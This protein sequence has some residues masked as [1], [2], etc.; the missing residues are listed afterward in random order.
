MSLCVNP[1]CPQP[2]NPD[3]ALFC[4]SCGSELLLSGRYR[5]TQRL[6]KQGGFASTY[7][8]SHGGTLK[9]LKILKEESPKA[10][11]LFQREIEVLKQSQHP[12][13]P[14]GEEYF[15]TFPKGHSTPLHCLVMEKVEGMDL[16]EYISEWGI[17][18]IDESCALE[19]LFQLADILAEIHGQGLLHRDIKPSNIILRPDGQLVLIDFG[20]VGRFSS[21]QRGS[22]TYVYTPGYAAPEQ[23]QGQAVPQ[24][25]FF[26]LGR[27]FVYLLTGK[28][29]QDLFDSKGLVLQWH[30]AVSNLSPALLQFIDQ[31]MADSPDQRP[32]NSQEFLHRLTVLRETLERPSNGFSSPD[33]STTSLPLTSPSLNGQ[34]GN[35]Q[36]GNAQ[37][38]MGGLGRWVVVISAVVAVMGLVGVA[39]A[40]FGVSSIGSSSQR[41]KET[42]LDLRKTVPSGRFT[43]G[44]STTWA[45][46]RQTQR[47]IDVAISGVYPDFQLEYV[48]PTTK[49]ATGNYVLPSVREGKCPAKT[50][51]NTGICMLLEGDL[52][53]SQSSVALEKS[54]YAQ[55]AQGKVKDIPV[56]YDAITVVVHPTLNVAGLTVEQLRDIYRGE[57][58]NWSHLGGPNLP[59]TP[60]SRPANAGGTVSSFEDLVMQDS[61]F[62]DRAIVVQEVANPTAGIQQVTKDMGGIFYGSAKEMIVDT[63]YTKPLPIGETENRFVSPFREPL[64]SP[65]DCPARRN[66]INTETIKEISDDDTANS[67]R[68]PLTR[69]IFVIVRVDDSDEAKAGDAYAQLL[70]TEQGQ[71]LLEKAGFVG[72]N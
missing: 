24:S 26:S 3:N 45:T 25:D 29:P 51:S 12:G 54:K 6:S 62:N 59:I 38:G 7:E 48:D 11:E 67:N 2:H 68:Y 23:E 71:D 18:P 56:A 53:F 16:E 20:A 30:G 66:Q 46:T 44:G 70:L 39:I 61:E 27:T 4:Q 72:L 5:V 19:W 69:K 60:Y 65:Q 55:Q 1:N 8:V 49:D 13:I 35:A 32:K 21:I 10:I 63:C 40:H 42:F 36:S 47:P 34:S 28:R 14:K 64:V 57:L 50:G 17:S 58:T 15:C 22:K 9:I 37:S 43:F 31:L 41:S 52:S 33:A